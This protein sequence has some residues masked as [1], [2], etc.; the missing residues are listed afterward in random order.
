MARYNSGETRHL[1][2]AESIYL[3]ASDT[4]HRYASHFREEYVVSVSDLARSATVSAAGSRPP[5]ILS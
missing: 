1:E 3:I 5:E 4:T 2:I